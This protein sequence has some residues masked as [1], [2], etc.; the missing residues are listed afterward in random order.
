MP[1]NPAG[2]LPAHGRDNTGAPVSALRDVA[3][4]AEA[5][6]QHCPRAADAIQ[7]PARLGRSIREA[8]ARERRNYNVERVLGLAAV[9]R[10]IG[11]WTNELDLLEDGTWPTVRDDQR[12]C[13]W[14][15]RPDVDEVDVE[16]VDLGLEL[17]KGV[18]LR[19]A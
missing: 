14:M 9:R 4:V 10:R 1:S 7:V 8:E 6:H 16:A 19:F 17:G 15:S 11:E 18:Q 5:L 13:V 2:P 12:Q 3:R